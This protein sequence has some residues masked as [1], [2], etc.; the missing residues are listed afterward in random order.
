MNADNAD[1]VCGKEYTIPQL[2]CS[3]GEEQCEASVLGWGGVG[4]GG[5][6]AGYNCT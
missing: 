4:R 3:Q 5:V 2:Q 1:L 6:S